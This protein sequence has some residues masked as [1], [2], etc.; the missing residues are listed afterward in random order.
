M[1]IFGKIFERTIFNDVFSFLESNN[2]R[3][4]KQTGFRPN[5]SYVSLLLSIVH[6][7]YSNFDQNPSPEVRVIFLDISKAFD[8]V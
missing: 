4:P 5:D 3:T 1:P 7:I 8:K 6:S 2:L